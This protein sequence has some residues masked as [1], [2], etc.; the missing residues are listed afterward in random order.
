MGLVDN[1]GRD[2]SGSDVG[3][4]LSS[5]DHIYMGAF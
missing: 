2:G 4:I 1:V 5:A 3:G